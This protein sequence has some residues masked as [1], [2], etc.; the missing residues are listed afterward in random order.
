MSMIKNIFYL[1]F[2]LIICISGFAQ[3]KESSTLFNVNYKNL[4]SRADLLYDKP[5]ARSEEGMPVGNGVMGSLVWTTP[6]A[7]HFQL[8]RVDVFGNNSASNNFYER[9]TDYCGGVGFVDIEMINDGIFSG[10]DFQ[11]HLSC[12][13]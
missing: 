10:Q 3:P 2:S 4:I 7:I 11:Q 1:L 6:S 9:N 8:N 12:Y 13:N 5:V